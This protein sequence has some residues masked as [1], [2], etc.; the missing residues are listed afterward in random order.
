M[1]AHRL[2]AVSSV[3][4]AAFTAS[5]QTTIFNQNFDGGYSGSFSLGS[6]S[7]GSPTGTSTTTLGSGGN[8]NGCMQVKMTTT[9]SG[10]FYAGQAQLTTV[11]GNTDPNPA[12]YVLSLDAK[13][14]A[15][16]TFVLIIQTWPNTGFGGSGPVINAVVNDQLTNANTWQTFKVNLGTVTTTNATGATWQLNFQLNASQWGGAG[17]TDTLTI[18]NIVLTHLVNGISLTSSTNPSTLGA[19][20][21]FTAKIMTNGVTA[22]DATGQV[23]FSSA[24]G[25]FSTN[26]V[27]A[28]NATS[29]SFAN[30]PAGNNVITAVY[31]GGNYPATTNTL[32]QFVTAIQVNLSI[33]TDNLV[34]GFQ[35]WS[36]ATV[37]FQSQSPAPHSGT[38]CISVTDAGNQ[39][40]AF[41]RP[42]FNTTPYANLSFWINGGTGGQHVQVH[43][44]LDNTAEAGSSLAPLSSSW[45]QITIPLSTLHVA[46]A[47]NCRGFW[48]QG[49]TGAAQAAFYVDDVQLV[50]AAVPGTV[51]LG[52]N[53]AQ[54]VGTVDARQFGLNTA[55]WDGLLGNSQ[56]LPLLQQIGCTALRW[57]GG[58]T[59]DT[60]HWASDSSGNAIFQNLATNLGAQ[61]FTTI[62]YGSGTPSE[63]VAWVR[64]ANQTNHCNFKYWEVGNECYGTWENDTHAIQWDPYTYATNAAV[65]IQQMKA[66][67]TNFPIKVGVVVVPG[68]GSYS[69]N[70]THF[71]INP[72]T[73]T[74]NYGWTPIVLAQMKSLG[75]LPDYL[76]Y[77]FYYQYTPSGWAPYSASAD[78]DPLLLQVAGNPSPFD[79]ADWASAA[80]NLRQ[81]I[82]DYIGSSGS[83]I[84]LCVTE[85]N[86]D[87]GSMGRQSTSLVNALYLAD[88]TSQLLKSEFRSYIWWDLHNGP[89][90]GNFDPT[91]YGWRASGDYG[92]LDGGNVPYP[93][94]YAEKLLR[95]F[96][97]A[98]D[99]VLNGTSDN[100][101]LSAYAVRRTNGALTMLVINKHMTTNLTGQIALTNF[102][103]YTTATVQSYGMPQDQAAQNNG[104]AASQDIATNTWPASSNFSYVFPPLSLTLFT[105]SPGPST[106][107]VLQVQPA[108][109]QLQLQG[110]AGTYVIQ[111]SANLASRIWTPVST[112]ALAGSSTT[113]NIP[114]SPGAP[115]QFYRAV[116]QP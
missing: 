32:T 4:V 107:S 74:T 14:S 8:P 49:S 65:C 55:T 75:V 46:N 96:A 115:V 37:N 5:A 47:P 93:T 3:V 44:L 2:F 21:S 98:G 24:S 63:A 70:A 51:H 86:S 54:T 116:W 26:T 109:V 78:S 19:P 76:I 77:H 16:A 91:I 17:H 1:N 85:N 95:S 34:N 108:Q 89:M 114:V 30:L 10:D 106:L 87:A 72:R 88:S 15:A 40:L 84:E 56:T 45:Q 100:L 79:W 35:N 110:Q 68:E 94:F 69:N 18:D 23:V 105:F 104:P 42:A 112:N 36:W 82:T 48:L 28:G 43:G 113:I 58:S 111:S 6:Y 60:Y 92:I 20:V 71:A 9:T 67:Y 90:S 102:I 50:A 73:G 64:S 59:S 12:N 52:V 31:S 99:S 57:P 41:N 83:N 80:A 39:A 61:V 53:A 81:Q 13:G 11:S 33:Y 101:F 29:A 25:P 97:R 66:A 7:G 62:N 38:Y 22:G 103:P 27:A